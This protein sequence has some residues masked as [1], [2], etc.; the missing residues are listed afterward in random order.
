MYCLP[1]RHWVSCQVGRSSPGGR[2]RCGGN[3][4]VEERAGQRHLEWQACQWSGFVDGLAEL[5]FGVG[6]KCLRMFLQRRHARFIAVDRPGSAVSPRL[7][8]S[9]HVHV[10][11]A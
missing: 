1:G 5:G 8:R 7:R 6:F 11:V 3:G 4:G 9:A 10:A 2:V